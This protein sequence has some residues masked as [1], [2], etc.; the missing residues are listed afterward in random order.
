M[1]CIN[2]GYMEYDGL[3]GKVRTGCPHTPQYMSR[4]CKPAIATVQN[5]KPDDETPQSLTSHEDPV[6]LIVNKRV[7]RSSTLYEVFPTILL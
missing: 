3:P 2:A 6:G 4:Y 7:T 5:I 1:L